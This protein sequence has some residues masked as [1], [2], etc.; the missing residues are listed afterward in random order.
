M[1]QQPP[2]TESPKEPQQKEDTFSQERPLERYRPYGLRV[3]DLRD[4]T[5]CEKQ[6][7]FTLKF[8]RE[9]TKAMKEGEQR[10]QELHE[11]ITEI[12]KVKPR[13]RED[14]WGLHLYNSLAALLQLQ[15]DG[16]C[17]ELPVFGPIGDTWLVGIIDE[18][19]M[20]EQNTISLTDTK[21]RKSQ[22]L[23]TEAQK[24]TTRFQ[25][26]LYKGLFDRLS[27]GKTNEA[28]FFER[29][30]VSPE[31]PFTEEFQAG[32]APEQL[33]ATNLKTLAPLVFSCF[34]Q[35]PP[36]ED[37]LLIR[38]EWQQDKSLL[39]VDAFPHSEAWLKI[40]INQTMP[41]WLGRRPAR[42]V[43]HNEKWKCRF[44]PFRGQCSFTQR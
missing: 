36:I 31:T 19:V 18:L 12:I 4:Q 20:T 42:F 8:G 32:F 11:E 27:S 6:L 15:R 43:P 37:P 23:P 21:T 13:S 25:M 29:L 9:Q 17:R 16:I 14:L 38:Y 41:F 33:P 26:M 7:E 44:C 34:Q 22:R 5:W 2:S 10:H 35:A 39:G 40:Q 28:I 3:T 30:S 1:T 24:R